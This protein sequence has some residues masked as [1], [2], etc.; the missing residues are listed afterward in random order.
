MPALR[1]SGVRSALVAAGLVAAVFLAYANA[2]DAGFQFDDWDVIVRDPRVQSLPAW[3]HAMPGI[4]PLLKLS[5]ALNHAS[6]LGVMG[7][8]AFNV[9]VHAGNALLIF[10]LFQ[11]LAGEAG[12]AQRES[13]WLAI[14]T[15]LIFALHP[16]QT[17]AVTYAS[18]RSTSLCALFALGSL[19][20]WVSGRAKGR[21]GLMFVASPLLLLGALATKEF[22]VVL[23]AALLLWEATD[24]R[25]PFVWRAALRRSAVHW[26]VLLVALAAALALPA[27]QQFAATSLQQRGIGANLIAELDA[28]AWLAGQTIALDRLNA[29]PQ[30]PAITQLTLANGAVLIALL[31]AVALAAMNLRRRTVL[32]FGILWFLLWLAPTNSILP[33]LDLV[34]DRQLYVALAGP[35]LLLAAGAGS[36]AQLAHMHRRVA[37]VML[38]LIALLLG[39]ATRLRNRVYAD[40][41]VFWRDVT[42]KSPQNARAFNNLGIALAVRCDLAGAG[43]A[44]RHAF[45]LD[46][47]Y[48][49][50]AVNLRLL[51]E[52]VLPA[53]LGPCPRLEPQN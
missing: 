40:E 29:D 18:G 49:R 10:F 21:P 51:R 2:L 23:P 1:R 19:A 33:R 31:A 50:A 20:V 36:L 8:H 44:W 26:A 9:L 12:Y 47:D 22:A 11:R 39:T 45:A 4:R 13:E 43:D 41:V 35:A 17:E 6:G 3:W 52:G 27:Y 30:L 42:V 46:P 28:L 34:N 24:L 16:V 25:Q 53:G 37:V 5:Y 7:F 14:G 48:V 38:A 15:A 32:A